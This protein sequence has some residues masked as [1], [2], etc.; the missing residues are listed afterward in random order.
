MRKYKVTRKTKPTGNIVEFESAGKKKKKKRKLKT[1]VV[2]LIIAAVITFLLSPVFN[3]KY[4]NV[5][6]NEK[7]SQNN[8]LS[9]SS[10]KIGSNMFKVNIKETKER[11]KTIPYI[12]DANI[13]RNLKGEIT[14]SVTERQPAFYFKKG[15]GYLLSDK[16]GRYLEMLSK[17]PYGLASITGIDI[18]SGKLG[19]FVSEKYSNNLTSLINLLTEFKNLGIDSRVSEINIK[20]PDNLTFIF[21]GNKKIVMGKNFRTDYKLMML[22]A[23]IEEIAPSEKGTID[24]S[25]EGKALFTPS[26]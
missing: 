5:I 7:V 23:T 4:I 26:E 15:T 6:N 18:G 11:I 9:L 8:I 3:I 20:N 21:D 19:E 10:I 12:Q 14:I 2:V 1:A 16:E 22:K 17:K 25:K 13:F 24:L